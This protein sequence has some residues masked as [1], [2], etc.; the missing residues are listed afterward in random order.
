MH[1]GTLHLLL[2]LSSSVNIIWTHP[3]TPECRAVS[4]RFLGPKGEKIIEES[5]GSVQS[6]RRQLGI[7]WQALRLASVPPRRL[8][9]KARFAHVPPR[10]F[11]GMNSLRTGPLLEGSRGQKTYCCIADLTEAAT[12]RPGRDAASRSDP[13]FT[14]ASP[15]LR[16]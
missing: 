7:R 5:I 15:G 14:R 3:G 8:A 1:P 2:S 13:T 4:G 10:S 12:W 11:F 9:L 6:L 16:Q